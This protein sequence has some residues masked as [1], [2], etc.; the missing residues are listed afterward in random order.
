MNQKYEYNSVFVE[1]GLFNFQ[2]GIQGKSHQVFLQSFCCFY[3][4]F[5]LNGNRI[6]Y[7]GIF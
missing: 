1:V 6:S 7:N 2:F 5:E 3:F 4:L